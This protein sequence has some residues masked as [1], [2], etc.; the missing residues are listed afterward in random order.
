[1]LFF[2]LWKRMLVIGICLAGL[3]FSMPNLFYDHADS[4]ARAEDA[5]AAIGLDIEKLPAITDRAS[6]A[7]AEVALFEDVARY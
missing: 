2:P 7:A 1:M 6:A 4:A 3:A 5:L